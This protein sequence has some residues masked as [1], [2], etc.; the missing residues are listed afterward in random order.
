MV[1]KFVRA[2]YLLLPRLIQNSALVS[3]INP[4]TRKPYTSSNKDINNICI[5]TAFPTS[6]SHHP[7][8]DSK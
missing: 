3:V 7:L 4:T 6:H 1:I 5:T 2:L 8:P